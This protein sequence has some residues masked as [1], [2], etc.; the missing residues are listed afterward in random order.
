MKL[1]ELN[2]AQRIPLA[3]G[4]AKQLVDAARNQHPDNDQLALQAAFT[5][6][7]EFIKHLRKE[8]LRYNKESTFV[9]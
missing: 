5:G 4:M 7:D 3:R 9:Q 8:I 6:A 2:E 1:E